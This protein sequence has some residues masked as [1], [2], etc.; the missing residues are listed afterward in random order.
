[1]PA[2]APPARITVL[3]NSAAGSVHGAREAAARVTAAFARQGVEA[4]VRQLPG[5]QLVAAVREFVAQQTDGVT[6]HRQAL[7][8]AGG[9]GTISAAAG[10]LAGTN[11]PLGILP[12][13]TLNHFAKDLGLP[14]EVEAAA[15]VIAAGKTRK[16]DVAELNGRVFVNNS[17]IGLYPFMVQRRNAHQQRHG[18]GKMLATLPA[19]V[20]TLRR[21]SWHR[22]DIAAAGERQRIRTPCVFVGNNCY[23]VGL[24]ALGSRA[25]LVDGELD[26]HVVRQQS[27][28]GVL[29]LP[30]KIAL[31][32]VDPERDVQTF[33]SR[34]LE[35]VS[36]RQRWMRVSLDGEVVRMAT[37]LRYRS[38][39]YSLE[40]F[41]DAALVPAPS[42]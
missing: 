25:C 16:V 31:G 2:L 39:P 7:A 32:I 24:K 3:M 5:G 15:A 21:A 28:L 14:L 1:M 4:E 37:P 33:R 19:L 30:F 36:R 40:V 6:R 12:M 26:I 18:I 41:C 11:L 20:E 22:L 10:A 38:R 35:I 29:L 27:R 17:S 13:G 34:D 42:T 23:E 9:D 8:V